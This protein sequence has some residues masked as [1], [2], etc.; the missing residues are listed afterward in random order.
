MTEEDSRIETPAM[1]FRL[2][3]A[4]FTEGMIKEVD[5]IA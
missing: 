4:V 3:D 5:I 1:R 2:V